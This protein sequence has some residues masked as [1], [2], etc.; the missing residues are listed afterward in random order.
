GA[1][2]REVGA[3]HALPLLPGCHRDVPGAAATENAPDRAQ[4]TGEGNAGEHALHPAPAAYR[5]EPGFDLVPEPIVQVLD[6][7]HFERAG[8]HLG[9]ELREDPRLQVL[10]EKR[11]AATLQDMMRLGKRQ[12]ALFAR[13]LPTVQPVGQHDHI[14]RAV[15]ERQR[16]DAGEYEP[17]P[18]PGAAETLASVPDRRAAQ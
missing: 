8:P 7:H 1:D 12:L 15:A 2:V 3:G 18:R 13:E 10:G 11:M 9:D 14:E 17:G 6:P 16:G 5:L 4:E